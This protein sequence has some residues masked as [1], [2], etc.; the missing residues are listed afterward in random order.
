[1]EAK[2]LHVIVDPRP[3]RYHC[4]QSQEIHAGGEK[5]QAPII[6]VNQQSDRAYA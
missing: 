6:V 1:M 4:G 5:I 3:H 2:K